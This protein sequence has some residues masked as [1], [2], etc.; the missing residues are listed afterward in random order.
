MQ[1]CRYIVD[2]MAAFQRIQRVFPTTGIEW[3]ESNQYHGHPLSVWLILQCVCSVDLVTHFEWCNG[4]ETSAFPLK[5]IISAICCRVIVLKQ[6]LLRYR[7]I[8]KYVFIVFFFFFSTPS[9]L[10]IQD[11]IQRKYYRFNFRHIS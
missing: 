8:Q 4:R 9:S 5:N 11:L 1:T 10:S 3:I 6:E 7:T 2:S